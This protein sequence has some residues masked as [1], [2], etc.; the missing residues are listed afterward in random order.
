MS[1]FVQPAQFEMQTFGARTAE[2]RIRKVVTQAGF[3]RFHRASK[4]PFNLTFEAR[5]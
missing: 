1:S 2:D 4:T 3:T 5:A